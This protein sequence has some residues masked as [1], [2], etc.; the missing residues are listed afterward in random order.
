[1]EPSSVSFIQKKSKLE[2]QDKRRHIHRIGFSII[3]N[4]DLLKEISKQF[5]ICLRCKGHH[6]N[7]KTFSCKLCEETLCLRFK[8]RPETETCTPCYNIV[9]LLLCIRE[10]E[11]G[12]HF[13]KDNFPLDMIKVLLKFIFLTKEEEENQIKKD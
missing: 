3:H 1:M 10:K 11:E 6:C 13:H 12:H 4:N 5:D 2:Y 8:K 9:S 7:R